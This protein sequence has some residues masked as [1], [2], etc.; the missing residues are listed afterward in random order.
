MH[1]ASEWMNAGLPSF[2]HNLSLG[3]VLTV[4]RAFG[5]NEQSY[6]R[7]T[8]SASTRAMP[9]QVWG[10]VAERACERLTELQAMQFSA[11]HK[12][13]PLVCHSTLSALIKHASEPRDYVAGIHLMTGI[14]GSR[15][16]WRMSRDVRQLDLF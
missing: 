7:F 16:M 6:Q 1:P 15:E 9:T 2:I 11:W 5:R 12:L 13:A 4:I 3:G 8:A 14:F 10:A